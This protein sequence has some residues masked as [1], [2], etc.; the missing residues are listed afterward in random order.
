MA[1]VHPYFPVDLVLD[2]FQDLVIPFEKILAVFFTACGI[3]LTA[4]WYTTGVCICARPALHAPL[5]VFLRKHT[6]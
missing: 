6:S 4:G 1:A 5:I 2:G 3:V